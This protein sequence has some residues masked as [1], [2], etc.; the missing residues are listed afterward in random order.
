MTVVDIAPNIV[1][2]QHQMIVHVIMVTFLMTLLMNKYM[3]TVIDDKTG[4]KSMPI[5]ETKFGVVYSLV[6][7]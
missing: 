4:M 7:L 6:V 2:V 1:Y 5:N 3:N